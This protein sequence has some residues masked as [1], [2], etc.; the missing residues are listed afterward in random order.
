MN[1]AS[2]SLGR[3][4]SLRLHIRYFVLLVLAEETVEHDEEVLARS[5]RILNAE[6]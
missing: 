5:W 3:F 4:V 2:S 1:V 6:M